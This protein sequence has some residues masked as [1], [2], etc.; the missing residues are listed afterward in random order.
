[1]VMF[2]V[3]AAYMCLEKQPALCGLF[4]ALSCQI[5]I[6]PL[7]LLP[8]FLFFWMHRR[9]AVLFLLAF[10]LALLIFW[11]EALIKFPALFARNVLWGITY[12][13]KLTAL[14]QFARVSFYD[15][16]SSQNLVINALKIFIVAVIAVMAWRRQKLGPDAPFKSLAY[17]WIIFFIFSPGVSAQHMVW[18]A[19]FVLLLSPTFY[20]WLTASSSLFLFFFYDVTAGG[21]PW[22]F[23]MSTDALNTVWTP[24]TIWPWAVLITG[25][26]Y[27]WKQAVAADSSARLFGFKIWPAENA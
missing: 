10:A 18:L 3:L 8:I 23:A 4:L 24:W 9:A 21:F 25:L 11:A 17:G 27:F 26:I 22:Y 14:P 6:V 5:K 1:M 16:A 2:L 20:G 7:L 12:C 13:L 15:L 19:P